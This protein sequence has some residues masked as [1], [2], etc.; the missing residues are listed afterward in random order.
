[1]RNFIVAFMLL[2]LLSSI[3]FVIFRPVQINE[4]KQKSGEKS[5]VEELLT[6]TKKEKYIEEDSPAD[7]NA[8]TEEISDKT[9]D[10]TEYPFQNEPP[11]EKER[12]EK[13]VINDYINSNSSLHDI[14]KELSEKYANNP[15][16]EVSAEDMEKFMLK[17]L[18]QQK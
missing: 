7:D 3:M 10:F 2:V 8:K 11:T 5:H 17:I 9:D 14:T 4:V 6:G 16:A 18:E 12:N 1:M 13:P 15:N